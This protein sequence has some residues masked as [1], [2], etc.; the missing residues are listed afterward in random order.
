VPLDVVRRGPEHRWVIPELPQPAI[1]VEAE[2]FTYG[3][4]H[5]VVVDV[6]GRRCPADGAEAALRRQHHVGFLGSDSVPTAQ[7]VG[8]TTTALV[9]GL[10]TPRVV[11]GQAVGA[12]AM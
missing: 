11:A 1:A 10:L 3:A 12:Q 4:G 7:V 6:P 8:A 5:V 2:E 9:K